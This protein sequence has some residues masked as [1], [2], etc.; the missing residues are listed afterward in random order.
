MAIANVSLLDT[1]F[2]W[3]TRTNQ[4]IVV[5]NELTEGNLLSQANITLTNPGVVGLN[6]ISDFE[7]TGTIRL[8][9]TN[10]ETLNLYGQLAT[11]QNAVNVGTQLVVGG[12]IAVPTIAVSGNIHVPTLIANTLTLNVVSLIVTSGANVDLTAGSLYAD[13]SHLTGLN[14]ASIA[15]GTLPIAFLSAD[16]ISVNTAANSALTGGAVNILLGAGVTLNVNVASLSTRGI[17]LL[18]DSI[19]STSISNAATPNS[20][21]T[22]NQTIVQAYNQANAAYTAANAGGQIIAEYGLTD[23]ALITWNVSS[24][25]SANVKISGN[26][27]LSNATGI[28]SGATY[29][30]RVKQDSVGS[31][32][33]TFGTQYI[34]PGN[35]APQISQTANT[36]TILTFLSDGTYMYGVATLGYPR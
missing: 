18:Q 35:V 14:A 27:Q 34:W 8:L 11:F 1:F 2:S 26:R 3:L 24:G 7:F 4:T 20:V 33:L 30:L 25:P 21:N 5:C 17:I 31:R 10:G 12:N 13:G 36:S 23:Q 22:V 15:T 9:K 16:S 28:Q 6:V 29:S 32:I 19:S